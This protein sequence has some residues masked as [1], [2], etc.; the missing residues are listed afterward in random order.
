[1][2]H[3]TDNFIYVVGGTA[4]T[5]IE[6]SE[7]GGNFGCCIGKRKPLFVKSWLQVTDTQIPCRKKKGRFAYCQAMPT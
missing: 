7:T 6:N 1:M 5:T 3:N 4:M 2:R